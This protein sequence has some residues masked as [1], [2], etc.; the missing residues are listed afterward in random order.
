MNNKLQELYS[1]WEKLYSN[2]E[3]NLL[4]EFISE[5]E[6]YKSN[7]NLPD[8]EHLWYKNTVVYSLYVDLFNVDFKGL[9]EKFDYLEE[10]GVNCLWLLPVLDSP[11]KDGGFDVRNFRLVRKSL[12]GLD[13]EISD[14]E[15]EKLFEDF[16]QKAHQK[17]FKIIFDLPLNHCSDENKYFENSK[18][19]KGNEYRD[20]FIWSESDKKYS[21][22]R[23]IFKGIEESN[24]KKYDDEYYFHRFFE[25]QPDLNYRNPEVLL[26]MTR[27]LLYWLKSGVDGFRADAIPYLWKEDGTDCENLEGTHLILKFMKAVL[28][29]VRPNVLF[30]AEACQKPKEVVKYFA[31]ADECNAAYHFP[32]MP[33]IYKAIASQDK[34]PIISI[35]DKKNTPEISEK[36]QWFL[37]LRCHDE[38]SLEH[39]YVSEYD[40]KYIY[41]HYCRDPK[42]DFREGEGISARLGELMEF[43]PNKILLAYSIILTLPGTPI[44]YY[45]DEFAKANDEKYYDEQIKITGKNDTRFLARGRIDWTNVEK[46]LSDENYISNKVFSELKKMIKERNSTH[47]FGCGTIDWIDVK[48]DS[49]LAYYRI[50]KDEK[51][52]ILNN[53]SDKEQSFSIDSKGSFMLNGYGFYWKRMK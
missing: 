18:N 40:R 16:L 42:W 35:L 15:S 33:M 23:V 51:F 25:F 4:D 30:L 32:L 41:N 7:L 37:F 53:L 3:I 48:N 38:L 1:V 20:Y 11:M 5:F 49:I 21:E 34:N 8:L 19:D 44:I 24:W 45:G 46:K 6:N 43:N 27:V 50:Y 10:L 2:S 13:Y 22:A 52:L 36:S 12:L 14:S 31:D 47:V 26:E 28:D 17:N 39:V 9:I 29:Y